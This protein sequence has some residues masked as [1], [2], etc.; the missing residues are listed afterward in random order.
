MTADKEMITPCDFNKDVPVEKFHLYNRTTVFYKNGEVLRSETVGPCHGCRRFVKYEYPVWCEECWI[1]IF[2]E[3]SRERK[4]L[5]DEGSNPEL[6]E[7]DQEDEAN[8]NAGGTIN[9]RKSK[10]RKL[11]EVGG[12]DD[13]MRGRIAGEDREDEGAAPFDEADYVEDTT[14]ELVDNERA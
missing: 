2:E 12:Y 8:A 1:P 11:D 4:R 9:S 13:E 3:E 6:D 14:V 7:V 10:R 5:L